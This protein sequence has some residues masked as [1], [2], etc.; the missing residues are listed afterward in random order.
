MEDK[1]KIAQK[2]HQC[3]VCDKSYSRSDTLR[4][5]ERDAHGSYS[6]RRR[7]KCSTC[8]GSFA[9]IRELKRH[10][11]TH[12]NKPSYQCSVCHRS[13]NRSDN[14]K[15]HE[16]T[17]E[18][19]SIECE[20]EKCAEVFGSNSAYERHKQTRTDEIYV[21]PEK[22][23]RCKWCPF[24]KG[25]QYAHQLIQINVKKEMITHVCFQRLRMTHQCT[26]CLKTYQKCDEFLS[27]INSQHTKIVRD[28]SNLSTRVREEY[29]HEH[30]RVGVGCE[31]CHRLFSN[32]Q[33]YLKH[34]T[35]HQP[36]EL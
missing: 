30:R 5:H 2:R 11:V 1:K 25:F 22:A 29:I 34:R 26:H 18:N 35:H 9:S 19:N 27:H 14:L 21:P 20:N 17:H 33:D 24:S 4:A 8:K 15:A 10:E 13:F 32:K 36:L 12:E 23:I 28:P 6:D 3:S 7:V 31:I 16:R